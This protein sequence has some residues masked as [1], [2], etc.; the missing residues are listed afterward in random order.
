M[1]L[2]LVAIPVAAIT[3]GG[4]PDGGEHPYVGLMVA[5]A[6]F[7]I[8]HD[9][10]A[11]T[12]DRYLPLWRCSGALISET[13]F[14]T[15]GHCVGLDPGSGF[16]PAFAGIWFDEDVD[17]LRGDMGYP[18]LEYAPYTG[19]PNPHPSYNPFAFFLH[20]L[21]VVELDNGGFEPS[22]FAA[23]PAVGAIDD[24]GKGRK[25]NTMEAVGYG[26]QRIV[27]N[28]VKGAIHLE[29]ELD[30][31]K[32]DLFVVNTIGVAGLGAVNPGQ[33]IAV[34]GDASRGGTCFGDSGGPQLIDGGNVIGAV[35]SFG[36]NG[37]CAGIG[38]GYR[39]DQVDD[40]AFIQSFL[41]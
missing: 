10:D 36:L 30:R 11:G 26:L 1:L 18:W 25:N 38:G 29:A 35:T 32:A 20:D 28:P 34:S 33:S 24:M 40:L 22:S 7:K 13:V 31:R 16:A 8:D 6:D 19:D 41:P 15:A 14:V 3:R 27:D 17:P 5:Y 39:I 21:G 4:E 12:A 37:N 2:V 23:L 9:G